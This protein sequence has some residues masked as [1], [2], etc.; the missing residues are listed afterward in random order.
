MIDPDLQRAE[1]LATVWCQENSESLARMRGRGR[2]AGVTSARERMIVYLADVCDLSQSTIAR[3][4]GRHPSS[5]CVAL[6]AGRQNRNQP[7]FDRH[8]R[9]WC[10]DCTSWKLRDEFHANRSRGDG[11]SSYCGPC[12]RVRLEAD[13]RRAGMKSVPKGRDTV[14]QNINMSPD[15]AAQLRQ[16]SE[17]LGITISAIVDNLLKP[18]LPRLL[19]VCRVCRQARAGEDGRCVDCV[20]RSIRGTQGRRSA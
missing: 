1:D 3:M 5:V 20:A 18:A 19:A 11:L 4:L 12:S 2:T 8:D 16:V 15:I 6:K 10:P 14:Q 9:K 17:H 13:R 7:D